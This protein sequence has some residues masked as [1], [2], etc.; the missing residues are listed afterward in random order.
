MDRPSYAEKSSVRSLGAT[1]FADGCFFAVWAPEAESVCVH[2]FDKQDRE[3]SC[4]A[5]AEKNDGVWSG[6]RHGVKAGTCYA[7]ETRGKDDP[8]QGAYFRAGRYLVDPY[9]KVLSRPFSFDRTLYEHNSAAF[10]PKAVIQSASDD[11]DWDGVHKPF[12][13]KSNLIVYELN[14][15]SFS[16]LC[17]FV[18]PSMRGKFLA[19]TCEE[20]I[21]HLKNLGVTAVQL[22]PV[23]AAM[24][25]PELVDRGL[26][27]LWGYNPVCFMAP[28]PRF[29]VRPFAVK[30]EFRTMVRE[31][32]RHGIAVIL[33]VVFNHTAEGGADGPVLCY[34]GLDCKNYYAF[35]KSEQGADYTDFLNVT[36]CGN[37]FNT[38]SFVGLNL[39]IDSLRYWTEIMGVDGF[40]FDLCVTLCRESHKNNSFEFE[41][42]AGFLKCC[43]SDKSLAKTVMIAEPWDIG[44]DGYHLGRFPLGWLEQ[45][46]LFRDT[47]RRFW[48]GDEATLGDFA[49]RLMGSRDVFLKNHRSALSSLNYVTYHDG[50]TLEDLVSY[51]RKY[52]ANNGKDNEDGSIENYSC[53]CGIEGQSSDPKINSVRAQLKR[54]LIA[55]L[56]LSQGTPHFL[57]GDEFSRT[58]LGNNNAF[59]QDNEISYLKWDYDKKNKDF[60]EF[61][62]RCTKLR[63]SSTLLSEINLGDDN[64]HVN[65]HTSTV[66][67]FSPDGSPMTSERWNN[68]K[69]KTLLVYA[70]CTCPDHSEYCC[71]LINNTDAEQLFKLPAPALHRHWSACLDTVIPDGKPQHTTSTEK[72]YRCR[73]FSITVLVATDN[74]AS[75][76]LSKHLSKS[77]GRKYSSHH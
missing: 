17:P 41:S 74:E 8:E 29:A 25:E 73:P 62:K 31:L 47:V 71:I 32:H 15:K 23:A 34:K 57:A 76:P 49:T 68:P 63:A 4:F 77:A 5:L 19:L 35:G 64:Y 60:I 24:S 46:D 42:K 59:C 6:F 40:R 12:L 13:S 1:A 33:D 39:V 65:S 54:N 43:L 7:L 67:W 18:P 45:N 38:D 9:A 51:S 30:D 53:N 52:N 3:L 56:F 48:R 37:S 2:L 14:V 16:Q 11:F 50:F 72:E 66:L 61:I 28:D 10:I 69:Q 22:N 55:T 75:V 58:Q 26:S 70:D 36:G 27:N 21:D 44:K 20:V